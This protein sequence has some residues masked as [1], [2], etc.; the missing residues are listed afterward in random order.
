M[1]IVTHEEIGGFFFS[2]SG[3]RWIPM[4]RAVKI[5]WKKKG[6]P[7]CHYTA[8]AADDL[9]ET[10]RELLILPKRQRESHDWV[11]NS[12]LN[13]YS[14]ASGAAWTG[15]SRLILT[16][17]CKSCCTLLSKLWT[18]L[19]RSG[20]RGAQ[21][22][23]KPAWNLAENIHSLPFPPRLTTVL[24]KSKLDCL[25]WLSNCQRQTSPSVHAGSEIRRRMHAFT[26]LP[27]CHYQSSLWVVTRSW[28]IDSC[29]QLTAYVT[30]GWVKHHTA[31][32]SGTTGAEGR[33]SLCVHENAEDTSIQFV[34]VL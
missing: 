18:D 3:N 7:H 6:E 34:F 9:L 19:C 15:C 17:D 13:F 8:F 28:I 33:Y 16:A 26:A 20:L 23:M 21:E 31:E 25:R 5:S 14:S 2:F 10:W 11:W 1:Q 29:R 24:C 4:V 32:C 30:A 27:V 22:V 12:P